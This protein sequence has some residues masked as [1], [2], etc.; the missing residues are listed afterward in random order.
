M[1]GVRSEK[2][3]RDIKWADFRWR[4]S[5]APQFEGDI[6]VMAA[7]FTVSVLDDGKEQHVGRQSDPDMKVGGFRAP[8]V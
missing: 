1:L 2:F 8:L 3:D 6:D 5:S 7:A 4:G